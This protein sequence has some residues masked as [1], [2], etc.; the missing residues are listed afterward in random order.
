MIG[1]CVA[2]AGEL[3]RSCN[4]RPTLLGVQDV[5]REPPGMRLEIDGGLRP[6]TRAGQEVL[7][8]RGD[9]FVQVATELALLLIGEGASELA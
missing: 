2:T 3:V 9:L 5:R 1:V 8:R 6:P 4:C 7:A